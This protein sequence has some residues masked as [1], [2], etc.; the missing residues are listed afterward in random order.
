MVDRHAALTAI[1]SALHVR[2]NTL[3][4]NADVAHDEATHE[5][6]RITL[7]THSATHT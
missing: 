6:A 7:H 3:R 5:D 2:A 4:A 1:R